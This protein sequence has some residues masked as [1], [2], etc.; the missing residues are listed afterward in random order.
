M[1]TSMEMPQLHRPIPRRTFEITP[2]STDSSH[3][4]SPAP[5]S[6]NPELLMDKR[7]DSSLS[8]SPSRTR[9]ILNLT[10]STLFGIYSA[11]GSDGGREEMSTPWGTGAQTP[12][13]RRS[14]DDSSLQ[15]PRSAWNEHAVVPSSRGRKRRTGFRGYYVPLALQTALLFGFGVAYGSIVTHLQETRNITPVPVPGVKQDSPS[16]HIVWGLFGVLLGNALPI[17]DAFWEE[18]FGQDPVDSR[19]SIRRTQ[20]SSDHARPSLVDSDLGPIW[21]SAVRSI[22]AFVG[23]A[24]AVVSFPSLLSIS[25][26][27]DIK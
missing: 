10:T 3:P 23:I 9:S 22:G 18:N 13:H 25:S 14:I 19:S 6:M 26:I 24:F 4:P 27:T 11:T 17:V 21:Y 8:M 20:S 15:E 5:E 1:Y 16:Y 12:S 2:A 7:G